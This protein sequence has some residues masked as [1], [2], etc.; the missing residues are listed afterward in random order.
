[1]DAI[2]KLGRAW[3]SISLIKR[4]IVG[5]VIGTVLAVVWPG[6]DIVEMLGTLFVNALKSVA[7]IL[8]FFLVISALCNAK[9]GGQMKTVI[10][11]YLVATFVAGAVAV[12]ASTLFPV[13]LTL[14]APAEDQASPEGIG[15]VLATLITNVVANPVEALMKANYLGILAWAVVLGIALRHAN[16]QVKSVFSSI[17]D[18]V[19]TVVRWII[20]L[21]PFGILGL[22]YT[23]VSTNG[24]EIFTEYGQLLLVLVGAML[25]IAFVTNPLLSFACFRKNPYGLVVRCLKDSGLTAFFTRS[26]AANIPVNMELCRKLGLNKDNYSLS[27]P[28]GATI[29][30]GGAAVTISVMAMMAAHTMGIEVD[31]PTAII[32]SVLSAISACGASGVAGGSLLLIPLACSLFGISN[33]IAMQVVGIGFVI[34]VIQDSCETALNSSSDVLFAASAEYG[35][36]RKQGRDFNPG[37]DAEVVEAA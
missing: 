9:G 37:K 12:I 4:I 34:G 28:L 20:S 13:D 8:V 25:F 35:E 7:P 36:W 24:L 19:S 15:Q 29:N 5:L 18:A 17:S 32:L 31:I 1:M 11:L 3:N 21:A 27:I 10:I 23:A 30:M 33:D 22:V 14:T 16:D 2:K 26:S 6:N